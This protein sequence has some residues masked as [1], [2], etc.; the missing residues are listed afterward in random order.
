LITVAMLKITTIKTDRR[1]R[2]VLEGKL[3][4]P[5]VAEV[6][7]EWNDARVSTRDLPL[8]VDL[9]NVTMISN[10]GE[11]ILLSMMRAGVRFVCGGVLNRHV[12][13]RLARK[14]IGKIPS[15]K[16]RAG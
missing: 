5:W 7:R 9:R 2:I 13:Q 16:T 11:D 15:L 6:D 8:I 10:E 1:C 14:L 12:L 4:A 3:V